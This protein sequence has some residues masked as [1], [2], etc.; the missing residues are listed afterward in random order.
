MWYVYELCN[1]K[2]KKPFYI[3][4]GSKDRM[5]QHGRKKDVS[6]PY[7]ENEIER[8]GVDKVLRRKIACF[9]DEREAMKFEKELIK[10]IPDL[11]NIMHGPMIPIPRP[12]IGYVYLLDMICELG[13]I[14]DQT[15]KIKHAISI[16]GHFNYCPTGIDRQ[17]EFNMLFDIPY[18]YLESINCEIE[19][20]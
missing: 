15:D 10:S 12:K 8:I 1:P 11:T 19:Y 6:N 7:K 13:F 14:K 3:G 4:K 9:W 17:E 2:T 16:I 5:H 18:K 20:A